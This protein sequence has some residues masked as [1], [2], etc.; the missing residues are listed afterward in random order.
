[1]LCRSARACRLQITHAWRACIPWTC[2]RVPDCIGGLLQERMANQLNDYQISP[3]NYMTAFLRQRGWT[4]PQSTITIPNVIPEVEPAA[5]AVAALPQ[6]VQ[7]HMSVQPE[8]HC[9]GAW[10][11]RRQLCPQARGQ[12]H[13]THP[14]PVMSQNLNH[15]SDMGSG[16]DD[17]QGEAGVA[18]G[19]LL[20]PGGAQGHQAVCGRG[21]LPQRHQHPQLRGAPLPAS[22]P[23]H[24]FQ[25]QLPNV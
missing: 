24:L 16:A 11:V 21:V 3:T 6:P 17:G 22:T 10:L 23:G 2:S 25:Q 5:A 14:L 19:L 4:L 13:R 1:M 9:R 15:T 20:A 12:E 8:Q 18:G 7:N